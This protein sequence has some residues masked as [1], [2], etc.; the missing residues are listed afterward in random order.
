MSEEQRGYD[1]ST[2][3]YSFNDISRFQSHRIQQDVRTSVARHSNVVDTESEESAV[4]MLASVGDLLDA[5]GRKNLP[6]LSL[7]LEGNNI[8]YTRN[9]I[10]FHII[11]SPVTF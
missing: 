4:C 10:S 9:L 11:L 7:D 5:P 1:S 6:T 2:P 3:S 8:S